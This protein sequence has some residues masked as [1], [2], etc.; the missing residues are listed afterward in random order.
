MK[1]GR[2]AYGEADR[3]AVSATCGPNAAT[4]FT[5]ASRPNRAILPRIRSD[6]RGCVTPNRRAGSAWVQ[7]WRSMCA[8]SA[9]VSAARSFIFSASAGVSSIASHTLVFPCRIVLAL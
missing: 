2:W 3:D 8:S 1:G 5:S 4:M 9:I 6:T 7:S